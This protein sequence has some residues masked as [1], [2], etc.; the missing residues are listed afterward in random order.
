M[1]G[2]EHPHL[3][4]VVAS[5]ASEADPSAQA[6]SVTES[7]PAEPP[8]VRRWLVPAL[9]VGMLVCAGGWIW[10]ARAAVELEAQLVTSR[11]ALVRSEQRVDA[12]E[13]YLGS[14]RDRFAALQSTLERELEALGGLLAS[15]PGAAPPQ[16]D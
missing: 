7:T 5:A 15:E 3:R 14:V 13:G 8:R 16:D 9:G 6:R 1:S 2:G 12:L 10:Q 4:P 11:A